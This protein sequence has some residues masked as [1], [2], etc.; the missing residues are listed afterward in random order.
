MDTIMDSLV[1]GE[2]EPFSIEEIQKAI[3]GCADGKATGLDG[4][5]VEMMKT[6]CQCHDT[7]KALA[8]FYTEVLTNA[9]NPEAWNHTLLKLLAKVKPP[10]KAKELRPIAISSHCAKV[11]SKLLLNRLQHE[12]S[13]TRGT[14]MAGKGRQPSDLLWTI[15]QTMMLAHEWGQSMAMIKL[16]IK[17]AFDATNRPKLARKI[18]QWCAG[19]P[20]EA[21]ALVMLLRTGHGHVFLPWTS[22]TITTTQ[23][24]RQGSPESPILFSKI[25]EEVLFATEGTEGLVFDEPETHL[26]CFMDDIV[27]WRKDLP[28]LQGTLNSILPGLRD[29]GLGIQPKKCQLF[30]MGDVKGTGVV[31]GADRILPLGKD[32]PITVLNI[33]LHP[34]RMDMGMLEAMINKARMKLSA[35][36]DILSGQGNYGMKIKLLES[37]VLGSMRWALG[38]V[39]PNQTVQQE[40]NK[41]Q[42]QAVALALGIKRQANEW[43]TD[44]NQRMCRVARARLWYSR[45]ERWGSI[46]L[47]RF[48]K[49]TGHRIR[50]SSHEPNTVLART[51]HFRPLHWWQS[52]QRLSMGIRHRRHFAYLMGIERNIS[53]AAELQWRESTLDRVEWA[54]AEQAWV[55]ANQLP[56]ASGRQGG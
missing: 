23:G 8:E 40:L 36:K 4:V 53:D 13:L 28:T 45:R 20:A 43:W 50:M 32:E 46:A 14:Q 38:V 17:A 5:P 25:V 21:R 52:Q 26:G 48:W 56:W 55:E 3:N 42:L 10:A 30:T 18:C 16:D 7:A 41:F 24:V 33:P 34:N 47:R 49:Y 15:K 22:V 2:V 19:K 27:L 39:Y 12:L 11:M 51:S 29:F 44:Y 6:M 35:I 9:T 37:T 54:R 31:I 1:V